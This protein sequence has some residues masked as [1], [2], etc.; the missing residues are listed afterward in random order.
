MDNPSGSDGG[1]RSLITAARSVLATAIFAGLIF[2]VYVRGDD[3]IDLLYER[4]EIRLKEWSAFEA[5]LDQPGSGLEGVHGWVLE[6]VNMLKANDVTAFRVS[7]GFL[8]TWDGFIHQRVADVAWP[9]AENPQARHVLRMRSEATS[10][11]ELAVAQ[12]YA[13]DRCE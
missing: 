1:R 13:L 4:A 11:T 7:P 5:S 6:V 10:C 2:H 9:I 3:A 8:T 12:E